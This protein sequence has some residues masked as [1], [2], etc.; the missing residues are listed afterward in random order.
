M[1]T[2]KLY[3]DIAKA[4][5]WNQRI[6]LSTE[7]LTEL[8]FWQ[9]CF[10]Q[11]NGQPI[12]PVSPLTSVVTYSD[13]SALGWGGYSVNLNGVCAKG[14]FNE[15]EIGESSTFRELKATLYVLESFLDSIKGTI[16]KHRS[17]NQNV[18]RILSYGSKEPKLHELALQFFKFCIANSIQLYPEWIP[19]SENFS[20]D[21]FS[22]DIDKDDY[23]LNPHFFAVADV[24]WGPHT[25]D[26]FSS[27]KTRQIP[28]FSSRWLNP[29]MEYLDAFTVSWS[30]ENNWLF[31]PPCI[32]PRVL[33][34]LQFSHT[35]GTLVAPLWTSAPWW[36][37]L[38]YDGLTF[39]P[40]VV[41]CI[42]IEPQPNMFIPAVPGSVIFGSESSTF[43]LLLLRICFA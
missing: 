20:A 42:V 35:N 25:I 17:D 26:R 5:F 43:K 30:G 1:W 28:R 34:H 11:Y 36:P 12:W 27:F 16:M 7:A 14:N 31:P 40:E 29:C 2:R 21:L 9:Q 13:A 3:G 18:V 39:R 8:D 37:L 32:I 6:S 22:K 41:D 15:Q 4:V 38:T 10:D 23:M 24:R 33:K 19:R